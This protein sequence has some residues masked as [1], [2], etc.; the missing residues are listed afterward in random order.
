V[1]LNALPRYWAHDNPTG[2]CPRFDPRGWDAQELHFRDKLFARAKTHSLFHVPVDMRRMFSKTLGAIEA[3]GAHS[4]AD[5]IVLSRELSPWSAEH[6][7]AVT[8]PVPGL[9][10]VRLSGDF[11]TRVFE[12]PF[13]KLPQW[14]GELAS[15]LAKEG[16]QVEKTFFFYTTCPRCAKQ[17]GKNYV[18]AVA[19]VDASG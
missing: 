4:D 14:A 15:G 8:K 7:F 5:F 17:Y 6:Y 2:C 18:V 1:D 16:R 11:V 10:I 3:A 19:Q 9:E 12:G 13:S